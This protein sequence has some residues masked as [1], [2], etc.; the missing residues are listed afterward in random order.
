VKRAPA[1]SGRA[2]VASG[3][4]A[5][6]PAAAGGV[7]VAPVLLRRRWSYRATWAEARARAGRRGGA[8]GR[9]ERLGRRCRA[10]A[11]A[12]RRRRLCICKRAGEKTE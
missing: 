3:T 11:V 9:R 8:G 1:V 12:A 10:M 4:G 7:R 5:E 6:A 2:P